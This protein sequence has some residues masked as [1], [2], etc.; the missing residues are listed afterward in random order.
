M[1][2]S[3]RT[4]SITT[5]TLA[6]LVLCAGAVARAAPPDPAPETGKFDAPANPAPPG[7]FDVLPTGYRRVS[8]TT[9][10]PLEAKLRA[11]LLQAGKSAEIDPATGERIVRAITDYLPEHWGASDPA[12][13]SAIG[14]VDSLG[15]PIVNAVDGL[16]GW[17]QPDVDALRAAIA[18]SIA[19]RARSLA[20]VQDTAEADGVLGNFIA[21]AVIRRIP[22]ADLVRLDD[23]AVI[24]EP[25]ARAIIAHLHYYESVKFIHAEDGAYVYQPTAYP[26]DISAFVA[27]HG[28]RMHDILTI[29]VSP[30]GIAPRGGQPSG[31]YA[32]TA[33][34]RGMTNLSGQTDIWVANGFDD[35]SADIATGFPLFFFYDCENPANNDS[36]RVSTNGYITFFQQGGGALDGTNFSNDAIPSTADPDGY[37]APWWDDL[38]VATNQGTADR[39]SYKTEGA[40]RSRVFTVEYFSMTR[41][42]GSTNDFH[43]FQVKLFET[44]DVIEL[45]FGLDVSGWQTD[46]LDSA[47]TGI[48]NYSGAGGDCGPNCLNS[49]NPPPPNDYRFTPTP[50]PDNDN[51]G[52]AI[53]LINGASIVGNLHRA[54]PDG[55]ATCGDSA[56]NRD[57]WYTFVA[58]CNGTLHADTC[59]SRDI[60]GPTT[61]IDT[62]LSVHSGCPGTTAN[63]L[64]CSDD[65]G[66]PGCAANDSAVAVPMTAGQRVFIRVTHFGE[67]A[68]RFMDGGYRLNL[69]FVSSAAPA[70]DNCAAATPIIEGQ[71]LVGSLLCAS[72]DGAADCG[73]SVTNPDIWYKFTAPFFGRLAVSACGSRDNA[74]TDTGP[75]TAVSIHSGCPGII[76]N[77]LGCNDDGFTP[78]CN[79]L[80][81]R[82]LAIV[83]AGQTALIRVSHFG[84]NAFR[85]GNG[86]T[87]IH[88]NFC[89]GA[90]PN[91]DGKVNGLD[92]RAF[93]LALLNPAAYAAQF[94]GC[95]ICHSDMNADDIVSLADIPLFVTALLNQ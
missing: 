9:R 75:D 13:N 24:S 26:D 94:P 69:N 82:A 19:A 16:P 70:N 31:C 49:N 33:F 6:A 66:A 25:V 12:L 67:I 40:V 73:S 62:V 84:S 90:D 41:L 29:E 17:A 1:H 87:A 57:V 85:V 20:A 61:G 5:P 45:H 72:N 68:F 7:P 8:Q 38:I 55:S 42:N 81:S 80:D 74:G 43:F 37:A 11:A 4:A 88:V 44:I 22:F 79:T 34:A 59:G 48:E 83:N 35:E 58:R 50:R 52:N 63:Q 39:V 78:G 76:A 60:D 56:N 64:A 10:A 47:T 3:R 71:L 28:A 32:R 89:R 95:D 2:H 30:D 51:C 23:T 36:V 54:T 53:E 18:D 15:R 46:T 14:P 21:Q 93:V 77:E 65:A 92:I 27:A 91:C 86:I